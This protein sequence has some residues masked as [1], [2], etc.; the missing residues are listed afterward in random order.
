VEN[1]LALYDKSPGLLE[2]EKYILDYIDEHATE[3]LQ[4]D[5][6][7]QVSPK[8]VLDMVQRDGLQI[9][10]M[11][12]YK[13]VFKW[14]EKRCSVEEVEAT[15]ENLGRILTHIMPHIRFPLMKIEQFADVSMTGVLDPEQNIAVFRYLGA[16][17]DDREGL[18]TPFCHI[19]R[20]RTTKLALIWDKCHR[21]YQISVDKKAVTYNSPNDRQHVSAISTCRLITGRYR[22][23]IEHQGGW[24]YHVGIC[25]PKHS[26]DN[27][28]GRNAES[29]AVTHNGELLHN[30]ST[31]S[32]YCPALAQAVVEIVVDLAQKQVSFRTAEHPSTTF[33]EHG[34]AFTIPTGAALYLA[35]SMDYQSTATI[36]GFNKDI[37]GT[38]WT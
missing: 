19:P 29:W 38:T 18:E 5:G 8:T 1:A 21:L 13:R 14:A 30:N 20:A 33:R 9:D 10:E 24:T 25:T 31:T 16:D 15:K 26:I 6:F 28:L 27:V 23:R 32:G 11:D 34:K 37:H 3:V 7:L 2:D 35:V 36:L 17:P 22:I 12:L 4:Q